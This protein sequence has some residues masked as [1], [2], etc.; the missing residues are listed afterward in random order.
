MGGERATHIFVVGR[1]PYRSDAAAFEA[2]R[3]EVAFHDLTIWPG[4]HAFVQFV[5]TSAT[6]P[7][8]LI[9]GKRIGNA[10]IRNRIKRRAREWLRRNGWVPAGRD[11]VLVAKDA[12]AT[13]T[14]ADVARDLERV[15][16]RIG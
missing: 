8:A 6:A 4:R 2:T 3:A 16:A 5:A 15:V 14:S 11:V 10:V 9:A 13:S 7:E 12:A 1:V